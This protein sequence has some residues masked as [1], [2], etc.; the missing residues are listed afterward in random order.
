MQHLKGEELKKI[1]GKID[2]QAKRLAVRRE[3]FIEADLVRTV[4]KHKGAALKMQSPGVAGIPDR[5]CIFPG[6]KI[7]FVETK[8]QGGILEP[9]QEVVHT[10]LKNMGFKVCVIWN[11]EQLKQFE[12]EI[13]A[14]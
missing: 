9:I 3:K 12:S 10:L 4:A 1:K 5:L 8:A 14:L 2:A 13:P 7:C 6:G 11:N